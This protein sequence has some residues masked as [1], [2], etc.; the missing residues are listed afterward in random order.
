MF[1]VL[2]FSWDAASGRTAVGR[3]RNSYGTAIADDAAGTVHDTEAGIIGYASARSDLLVRL[4][5]GPFSGDGAESP[6]NRGAR[7]EDGHLG[8]RSAGQTVWRSLV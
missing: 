4:N 3:R 7:L 5:V 2:W 8:G 1:D 6:C